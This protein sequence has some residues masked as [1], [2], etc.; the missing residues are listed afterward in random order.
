[1][2]A[3][4]DYGTTAALALCL[5]IL[6]VLASPGRSVAQPCA[7]IPDCEVKTMDSQYI[8]GW[9]TGGWAFTCGG[10]HPFFWENTNNFDFVNE[11]GTSTG[12]FTVIEN[13]DAENFLTEPSKFD[14]IITNWCVIYEY[15]LVRI[16]CSRVPQVIP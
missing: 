15:I 14:A 12:C 2:K 8:A 4:I 3:I 16:G 13:V 9:E 7:G 1:V 10:S 11:P 5:S 6:M